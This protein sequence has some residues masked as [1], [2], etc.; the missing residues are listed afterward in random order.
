MT[1]IIDYDAGNIRSVEKALQSLS[2]EA[3]VTRDRDTIL[4]ADRVIL[5]GV[6]AFG[7]AMEKIRGYGLEE[8][9]KEVV[10]NKTPFLGICLGLQLMFERSDE[11]KGVAGLGLLKGEILRIPESEGLKI[12]HIGWNSLTFPN[13]GRLF[14][15]IPENSYVYFVHSYYLQAE[16]EQIVKATCEYG[17]TIH[18]S[19]EEGNVFAC[20]FHPEKSGNVGLNILRAFNEE[21]II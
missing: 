8:V 12:P 20:Q 15:G 18:A 4:N 2:E 7:D 19:V 11:S 1:A 14:E 16:D 3:V 17:T 6:G 10:A 9:I 21:G 5:P 13:K